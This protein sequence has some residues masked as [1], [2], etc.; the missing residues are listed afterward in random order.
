METRSQ[1]CLTGG[2]R[3]AVGKCR[4]VL[5]CFSSSCVRMW[6]SCRDQAQA[7]WKC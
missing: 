6:I 4:R 3:C 1:S 5:W 7:W 2:R